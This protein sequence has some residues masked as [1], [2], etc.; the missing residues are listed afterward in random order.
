MIKVLQGIYEQNLCQVWDGESLSEP[1]ETSEGVKQ[2]CLLS[3]VLFTLFLNDLHDKL[4]GGIVIAGVTIRV[5]MYADDLVL[6]SE[7]SEGLQLMIDAFY[8]YCLT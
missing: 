1:F 2:G 4:P 3:P 6:I 5:L 7:S 8:E